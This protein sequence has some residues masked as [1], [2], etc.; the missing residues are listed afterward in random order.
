[1]GS[2]VVQ[3]QGYQKTTA[4]QLKMVEKL[5]LPHQGTLDFADIGITPGIGDGKLST[6]FR[7]VQKFFA[8]AFEDDPQETGDCTTHATRN[9]ADISRA[10]EIDI[11]KEPES[12][13]ARGATEVIYR[14]RGSSSPGMNPGKAI[15]FLTNYGVLLRQKYPWADLSKYNVKYAMARGAIPEA[16]LVEAA[17]H[18]CRFFLRIN[19]L[20]QARDAIASGFGVICG[21][22][23]GNDGVRDSRGVS[24][25]NGSWN[26]C[27]AWGAADCRAR[28][29]DHFYL[30][31]Q[32]W[33]LWN[34][35]GHPEWGPI[36]GGSFL[37]PSGDAEWCIKNGET[38]AVGNV[39][40][41]P[42]QKL[43]DYGSSEYL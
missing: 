6:P 5:L 9:A 7:S 3:H 34:R 29:K 26:H 38:W 25:F 35:G 12:F 13:V 18:S 31:L 8:K 11:R 17:K 28:Q 19:S 15:Q 14:Y 23:Y 41:F 20:E 39:L 1:M 43:P 21:S 27:M 30:V 16:A 10:V 36:P 24:K 2:K 40:G 33:G 32:S 37:M 4:L 22:K 42:P